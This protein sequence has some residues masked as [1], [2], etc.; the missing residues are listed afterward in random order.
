VNKQFIVNNPRR[1]RTARGWRI[2]TALQL[3]P[4][5]TRQGKE[6][7][8]KEGKKHLYISKAR[9]EFS[10]REFSMPPKT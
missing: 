9:V 10:R 8:G 7:Q 3:L 6:G 2:S 1:V 5:S 4:P